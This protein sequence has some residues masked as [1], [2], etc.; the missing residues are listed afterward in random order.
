MKVRQKILIDRFIGKPA[1]SIL[2]VAARG[3]ALVLRR[4][5]TLHDR[6]RRIAVSKF[7]GMGSIIQ[8]TPLLRTLRAN[9][10]QARIAFVTSESN[11]ELAG[12]LGLF[13][14]II[15]VSDAGFWPMLS[16]SVRALLRLW[17]FKAELYLDFE[18]YSNY[19][20][21]LA[22]LSCAENR[23]GFFKSNFAY[24]SGLYNY[25]I[26]FNLRS[27]VSEVYL[28][29]AR[30]LGCKTIF[31][32][33][34]RIEVREEDRAALQS[35]FPLDAGDRCLVVNPNASDLRIERRWDRASYARLIER[36]AEA[37]P[38]CK[39]VL[40][41]VKSEASYTSSIQNLVRAPHRDSVTDL[42]GK[43]SLGALFALLERAEL[44]ITNDTG[45]MH[46]SFA[47]RKK[48]VTLWGPAHPDQYGDP[49]NSISIYKNVYCSPCVHEFDIP[50]CKGDNQCMKSIAVEDVLEAVRNALDKKPM[51][52]F[53]PGPMTYTRNDGPYPLGIV[54][55]A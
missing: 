8:M 26:Y 34:D 32:E 25:L 12:R 44:L 31:R 23:V 43:L 9:Y 28:Q 20:S 21:V 52:P 29:S 24:R 47:L 11:R 10:P 54:V 4:D 3:L 19:S 48:T 16:T 18:I 13:D 40:I 27:P 49:E 42:A 55:K 45:P 41:G 6:F 35:V 30:L 14:N 15:T 53:S 7:V 39:L 38:D 5:H 51:I 36:I 1:A 50:P 33:L 2:N 37:Y 22:T 17:R 46:F